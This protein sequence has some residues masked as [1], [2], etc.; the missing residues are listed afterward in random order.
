M[1]RWVEGLASRWR[2]V[3]WRCRGVKMEGYCWLR[4]VE[5]PRHPERV[6]LGHGVAL[7]RGVT[8]LVAEVPPGQNGPVIRIGSSTYI[9]RNTMLDGAL[10]LEVGERCLLGPFCYVTD[11]DHG[12]AENRSELR[13]A[14][15]VIEDDCWLGAHVTVLKGVRIGRGSTIGAGSV[16]T[17]SVP[18]GSVAF[19]N[20]AVVRRSLSG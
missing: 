1:T 14:E 3:W 9:N 18:P 10:R 15:T 17:K 12:G 11:H 8:L 2:N 13:C 5:V 4:S 6:R 16:V 19:G 20:P 7:D